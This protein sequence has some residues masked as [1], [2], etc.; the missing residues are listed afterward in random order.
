MD[1]GF[2]YTVIVR[3]GRHVSASALYGDG[4]PRTV[5]EQEIEL[6]PLHRDTIQVLQDW[7]SR[8]GVLSRV[9]AQYDRLC[10]PR[11][12]EVLGQYLYQAIFPGPIADGFDDA[13]HAAEQHG[14]P[15]RVVLRFEQ[16]GDGNNDL[17][18]YAWEFLYHPA[19]PSVGRAGF[20][21]GA[22][23][24]LTLSRLLAFDDQ[25]PELPKGDLP[26]RV[27]F[28]VST[29]KSLEPRI[30]RSLGIQASR[31][32]RAEYD[33]DRDKLTKFLLELQS[34]AS[35]LEVQT[36]A[37]WDS[38]RI[39]RALTERAFNIIHVVGVCRS[40]GESGEV[41]V[42]LPGENDYPTWQSAQ[43]IVDMLKQAAEGGNLGLV[44]LHLC[45][46]RPSDYAATFERLAPRLV[47]AG[48]P[49]VLA[50][51][52]PVPAKKA[53]SFTET[54]YELLTQGKEIGQAVQEARRSL[55]AESRGDR[56]FGTPAL[57][58]QSVDG[59]LLRAATSSGSSTVVDRQRSSSET[60]VSKLR[61]AVVR[62]AVDPG[63]AQELSVWID[64]IDWTADSTA[65]T[66]RI[67][68]KMRDDKDQTLHGPVYLDM[69]D[70][71]QK[72]GA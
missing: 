68:A 37:S 34:D 45:E 21:I 17:A 53:T 27:L 43:V 61:Q 64:G 19:D 52:Y 11:T 15:L 57:Y 50:M 56:G 20:F 40:A 23:T 62:R 2:E 1:N 13:K 66:R 3:G 38:A 46:V 58:L 33:D 9:A 7:L 42:A 54:F 65:L 4:R 69:I 71:V 55:L 26:L 67:L 39:T 25:R 14:A 18:T 29:P 28:V 36:I 12:F 70:I 16:N 6:S 30:A 24:N 44:V 72:S 51:Q 59:Q 60:L 8:W 22:E 32:Q 5:A 48:I 31:E 35:R 47:Q 41:D 63:I 49:A 10:V